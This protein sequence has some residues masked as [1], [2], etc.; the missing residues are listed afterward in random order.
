MFEYIIATT[1]Y[2]LK[3]CSLTLRLCAVTALGSVPLA[4][5]FALGRVSGPKSLD[6]ALGIYAWI[7]RGTPLLLQLFF[8]YYGLSIFGISLK[9]FTAA[10]LTFII[11]YAAY[12]MEIFRSGIQS[13][14]KGQYEAAK[15]LNMTYQQAMRRII[16][17]QAIKRTLPPCCNEAITL[18][19]DTALVIVIG[20]GDLLRS[21]KEVF[22]RDFRITPFIIAALIYLVMTSGVIAFFRKIENRLGVYE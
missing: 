13:I 16:L 19:K 8:V 22:T 17:P 9:P 6:R 4:M 18:I 3:G 14:D 10:G 11:N 2:I 20:M 12:L 15:A 21:A 5:L 7:F 1:G